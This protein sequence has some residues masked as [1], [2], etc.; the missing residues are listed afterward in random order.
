MIYAKFFLRT[1]KEVA[2]QVPRWRPHRHAVSELSPSP[3]TPHSRGRLHP[4]S[5]LAPTAVHP[6][7]PRIVR[8]FMPSPFPEAH[9]LYVSSRMKVECTVEGVGQGMCERGEQRT[10]HGHCS[11]GTGVIDYH[12]HADQDADQ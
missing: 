7:N 8:S 1:E 3:G 10:R 12:Q 5:P 6:L 2:R 4:R 11:P 9:S